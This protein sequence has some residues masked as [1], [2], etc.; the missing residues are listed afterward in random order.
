MN[1]YVI[2]FGGVFLGVLLGFAIVSL[3]TMGGEGR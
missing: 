3:L 2:F 1:H